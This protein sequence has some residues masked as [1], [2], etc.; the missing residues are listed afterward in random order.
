M[1]NNEVAGIILFGAKYSAAVGA[2][3]VSYD[4]VTVTL[5]K[6]ICVGSCDSSPG[7]F[8]RFQSKWFFYA[9]TAAT[10]YELWYVLCYS[11][12]TWIAWY[13]GLVQKYIEN[14]YCMKYRTLRYIRK[15]FALFFPN[16]KCRKG[17]PIVVIYRCN[18]FRYFYIGK[19]I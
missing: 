3:P 19:R 4:G 12:F 13:E 11:L 10:G 8:V 17:I 7:G 2:E 6:D 15:I 9:T 14:E 1:F 5:I 18:F 16:L